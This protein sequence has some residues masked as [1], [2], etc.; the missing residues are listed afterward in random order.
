MWDRYAV[1]LRYALTI[2]FTLAAGKLGLDSSHTADLVDKI[3]AVGAAVAALVPLLYA[4]AKRPSPAAMEVAKQAD[5]VLAG[6]KDKAVVLT[7][8]GK[9]NITV[10][11]TRGNQG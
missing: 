9:P 5:K 7:P 10:Q 1:V 3:M 2:F 11:P 4:L 8:S 6:E